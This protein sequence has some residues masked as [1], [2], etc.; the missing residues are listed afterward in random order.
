MFM[1]VGYSDYSGKEVTSFY[2]KST[3]LV[4]YSNQ[5]KATKMDSEQQDKISL[6]Y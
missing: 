3:Q 2:T 6:Q 1:A 4:P 5:I